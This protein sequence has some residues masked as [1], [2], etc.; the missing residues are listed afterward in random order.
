VKTL[1]IIPARAGSKGLPGK[2]VKLLGN[3]PLVAYSIEYALSVKQPGDIIC[4]TTN[5][6]DVIDIA[7]KYG[8]DIPFKRPEE[9]ANDTASSNDVILHAINYYESKQLFFDAVLLLQPTSPFRTAGDYNK[10]KE[11]FAQD[12][13]MAVS[14]KHTKENPYFTIFEEDKDGFLEK[15]KKSDYVTRQ[16]CPPVFAYNGS[17]YLIKTASLKSKGLHGLGKIR[18]V[19]MPD[20]RSVDIDTMAD[21]IMAEYFLNTFNNNFNK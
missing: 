14:V 12:C 2:N 15:S 11:E 19:I 10:L 18:K 20:E 4:I 1:I 13:D 5:D 17:M 9:L 8:L 3:K 7:K 16:A 6:D 21:W